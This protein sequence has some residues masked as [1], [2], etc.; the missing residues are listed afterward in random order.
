MLAYLGLA[1]KPKWIRA[2]LVV[3]GGL[4]MLYA[5]DFF[6]AVP[7]AGLEAAV[8]GRAREATGMAN[9]LTSSNEAYGAHFS[10]YGVLAEGVQPRFGYSLYALVCSAIPRVLWPDR[11]PD[12]YTYYS[13]SVGAIQNQG[14]SLHHAT[15]WYLNLGYL[16][17]A[18]GAVVMGLVWAY[19]LNAHRRPGSGRLFRLFAAVAP[20]LFVACLP[21]LIRAGPEGLQGFPDRRCDDPGGRVGDRLPSSENP[22]PARLES[23]TRLDLEANHLTDHPVTPQVSVII[24]CRNE[25]RFID[26][27]VE[28]VLASEYPRDRLEVIVADGMSSDGTRQQLER[29]AARDARVRL[30]DN[31]ARTTPQGLNLAIAAAQGE[32]ILRLDAHAWIAPDYIPRAVR[33]LGDWG[34]DCVGGAMRTVTPDSG[35]FAKAIR[36]GL[37]QP[38]GVGDARFRTG[39]DQPRWV[40]TVFGA[41]WR[42]EVFER[43]GG[44]DERLE[45]SQDIEFSG[46]LRRAG[47]AILMS[48]EMKIDYYAPARLGRFWRHNWS[49]GVWAILPFAHVPGMVVRWRHL[50]PLAL[51]VGLAISMAAAAWSGIAWLAWTIAGPYLAAN[52]IASLAAA[53]KERGIALVFLM[54][55]VFAS[56]HFFYGAGSL[57]GCARLIGLLVNPKAAA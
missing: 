57:W 49:N 25:A 51:V 15:G 41:C 11:P 56:L 38:F 5:I 35:A 36:I 27:C 30:V 45:R 46:R 12:I 43:I 52:L 32:F 2:G 29:Y 22:Q 33:N 53:R 39:S 7:F 17:V 16:G 44:F 26:Q 8:S 23:A 37:S 3:A 34:A 13:E 19:C 54:P 18:L 4:W 6:R 24:P 20:W 28:S 47:G 50:T 21:P 1:R 55:V 10:M 31:P 14:Y 42:R 40:D 9:F 48:P